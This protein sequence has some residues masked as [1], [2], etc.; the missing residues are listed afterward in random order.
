[1]SILC[2][3][4]ADNKAI[5]SSLRHLDL[6]GNPGTLAGDDIS[7]SAWAAMGDTHLTLSPAWF[8]WLQSPG[9]CALPCS[10]LGMGN[11]Q[12]RHLPA[13]LGAAGGCTG[14]IPL[15]LLAGGWETPPG[16]RTYPRS[17][18]HGAESLWAEFIPVLSGR[19]EAGR[20]WDFWAGGCW[21]GG[22]GSWAKPLSPL[23]LQNLQS[24]LRQ[25]HSLSHLSLASTDCPLDAV[26]TRAGGPEREP[27]PSA[28]LPKQW[29]AAGECCH[30]IAAGMGLRRQGVRGAV[31]SQPSDVPLCAHCCGWAGGL[32]VQQEEEGSPSMGQTPLAPP[33]A[34]PI[35]SPI[36][37]W[38][39]RGATAPPR[40]GSPPY[41]GSSL[42][43]WSMDAMPASSIWISQK[44]C[45]PTSKA[46]G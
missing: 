46:P 14:D 2:K 8:G 15:H 17:E 6:S 41:P 4:L 3:A 24:L 26:S 43:P 30:P 23:C 37:S 19:E 42:E 9:I 27:L 31:G 5:G 38:A 39:V 20:N 22:S 12:L 10:T 18:W 28:P 33:I 7:V 21:V 13:Y 35:P 45:T 44:M 29:H 16:A 36:H 11:S 25:C 1:M 34:C 32:G 40:H